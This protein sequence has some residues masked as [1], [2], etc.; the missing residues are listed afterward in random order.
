MAIPQSTSIMLSNA[1][2][3]HNI[4]NDFQPHT[5]TDF[6]L[7]VAGELVLI[8]GIVIII[9][10]LY[11]SWHRKVLPKKSIQFLVSG[12]ILSLGALLLC[13]GLYVGSDATRIPLTFSTSALS[14]SAWEAYK[15]TYTEK[16][17]NRTMDLDRGYITTSEGQSYTMLRAVWLDD[18]DTYDKS[19]KWTR[20][21][22]KRPKDNLFSWKYGNLG[23][24]SYGVLTNEGG[25]NTAS[26]A[27]SDIALSLVFAYARWQ[28]P[29][30]ITSARAIVSDIWTIEVVS[31]NGKPYLASNNLEKDSTKGTIIV[32]PSYFAPYAYRIFAKIDPTHPWMKLVDNSYTVL[33]TAM[34]EHLDSGTSANLVP[35]WIQVNKK[36]GF[37]SAIGTSTLNTH[38]SYDAMRAPWRIALDWK[39]N[40]EPRAKQ[41]LDQMTF[42]KDFWKEKGK[43]FTNYAHNGAAPADYEAPAIYGGTIG[44]FI[45]SDPEDAPTVY[46]KKLLILFDPNNNTWRETL[47]YYDDNWAWFGM[48]LYNNQLPNLSLNIPAL[49]T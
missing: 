39:W 18:K 30:Y 37:I 38:Y 11:H 22:L 47:S 16:T 23:D 29:Q 12:F 28:D 44:Y 41:T 19:W 25:N 8:L 9:P 24:G 34:T 13:I 20:D 49:G 14:A 3:T 31:I 27:D 2:T 32:N 26:D 6:G 4:Y 17:S 45:V 1:T 10:T 33:N 40:N 42:L 43:I 7:S 21:N 36:T 15:I 35:D 5:S 48:A 46:S